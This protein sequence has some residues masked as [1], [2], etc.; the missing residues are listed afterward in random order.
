MEKRKSMLRNICEWVFAFAFALIVTF[1]IKSFVLDF[2]VVDGSSMD[3]TLATE[4]RLILTK[5]GYSPQAGDIIVF[6]RNYAARE[7]YIENRK[8]LYGGS[9]S[10]FEELQLRYFTPKNLELDAVYYVKRVIG[11]PGDVIDIDS[12]TGKVSINGEVLDEPYI[13]GAFTPPYSNHIY[14]YTIEKDHIFVMGDNRS[15]SLDS[16]SP[17]GTIPVQAVLGKA[18]L[19][20][21]PLQ[22]FGIIY[23]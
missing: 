3:P 23:H 15:N 11:M 22:A 1:S 13:N 12:N 19:R 2:V 17:L 16:R 18:A 10:W 9:I 6:D 5:L 20:V 21:W 14:P 7:A 8:A 4:D